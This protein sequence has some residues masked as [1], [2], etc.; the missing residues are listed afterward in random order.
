VFDGRV[1]MAY[2]ITRDVGLRGG[3]QLMY[4]W[5]GIARSNNLTTFLN[6][7]SVNGLGG[8]STGVEDQSMI[9]A[10]FSFGLDWNY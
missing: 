6:P 4:M 1:E 2:M 8:G 5:D 3:F 9:A 7:N 10:G